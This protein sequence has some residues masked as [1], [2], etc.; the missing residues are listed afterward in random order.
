MFIVSDRV[1]ETSTTT[2]TGSVVLNGSFGAFQPF[3]V[4]IGDGNTTYYTIENGSRWEVGQGVFNLGSNSLSRDIVFDSSSGGSK[5]DLE[6]VSVVFCTLPA[7]KAFLKD[8][9][10]S[11]SVNNILVSGDANLD[12]IFSNS[13]NNIGS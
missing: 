6:G 1:K 7:S 11:V 2:G 10:E 9:N 4:G 5:I 8:P 12:S 3:S 13:I